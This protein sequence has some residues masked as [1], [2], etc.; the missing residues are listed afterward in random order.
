MQ[1]QPNQPIGPY[2]PQPG[3]SVPGPSPIPPRPCA[4][5]GA[6]HEAERGARDRS[7]PRPEPRP[8][9]T[10]GSFDPDRTATA[11]LKERAKTRGAPSGASS[12]SLLRPRSAH[13]LVLDRRLADAA[14]AAVPLAFVPPSAPAA[15]VEVVEPRVPPSRSRS[16]CR[17]EDRPRRRR[18][19][20][21]AGCSAHAR[22]RRR[23]RRHPRHGA[24][25]TGVPTVPE[26]VTSRFDTETSISDAS[27]CGSSV[28]RSLTSSRMR[29]SER[30]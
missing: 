30:W 21:R 20:G 17:S 22:R 5:R 14:D 9:S 28:S 2:D 25:R 26:S 16:R 7:G 29:S 12:L 27:T 3:P 10:S 11:R 6:G 23:T 15:P 13:T 18:L 1:Q 24:S 4:F 19:G 8:G